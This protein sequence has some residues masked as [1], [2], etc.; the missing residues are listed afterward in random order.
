M[1]KPRYE[2]LINV[3]SNLSTY[4]KAS[5]LL[6]HN[7]FICILS[8]P[9][10]ASERWYWYS[11]IL[12]LRSTLLAMLLWLASYKQCSTRL[13][14]VLHKCC[15]TDML[16][17]LLIYLHSPLGTACPWDRAYISV[18]PLTA[19]LQYII[20]YPQE[21]FMDILSEDYNSF[22]PTRPTV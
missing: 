10:W 7:R 15:N 1:F 17:A 16:G 3:D 8:F 18:K 21:Y 11:S 13:L 4:T 19:V 14:K 9:H 6:Q 12:L 22:N 5:L 20:N 2:Q